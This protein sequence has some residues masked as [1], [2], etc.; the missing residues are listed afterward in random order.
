MTA[1]RVRRVQTIS[2]PN[3]V[4]QTLSQWCNSEVVWT[5]LDGSGCRLRSANS[6]GRM[7]LACLQF[8]C[9]VF[10]PFVTVL[11][12]PALFELRSMNNITLRRQK[13]YK[14]K[15]K[16][17]RWTKAGSARSRAQMTFC[18]S[19]AESRANVAVKTSRQRL[20]IATCRRGPKGS[21]ALFAP[22]L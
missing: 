8:T 13:M 15:K 22:D 12:S 18:Q 9:G 3:K 6:D 5:W 14:K 4:Y 10:S 7:D 2:K 21:A 19:A 11:C 1:E 20:H 16:R 17:R